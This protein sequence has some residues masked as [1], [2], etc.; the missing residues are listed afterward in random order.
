MKYFAV[1]ILI[2]WSC[3]ACNS[4]DQK[5]DTDSFAINDAEIDADSVKKDTD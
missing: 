5:N 1:I 3:A 4:N 2:F